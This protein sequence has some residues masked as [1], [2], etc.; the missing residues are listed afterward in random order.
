MQ[1]YFEQFATA[2]WSTPKGD[3]IVPTRLQHVISFAHTLRWIGQVQQSEAA[4]YCVKAE[5]VIRE[6]LRICFYKIYILEASLGFSN[7]RF[8]KVDCVH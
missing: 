1:D 4:S 3:G 7:H 8:G 6:S 5:I 2:F